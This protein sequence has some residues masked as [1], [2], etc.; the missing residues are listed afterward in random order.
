MKPTQADGEIVGAS[1]RQAGRRESSSH[2]DRVA[3]RGGDRFEDVFGLDGHLAG[4]QA[5]EHRCRPAR[6]RLSR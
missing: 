1:V 3:A 5:D 4:L 2:A 6:S